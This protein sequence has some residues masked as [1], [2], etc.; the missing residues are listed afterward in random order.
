MLE[1]SSSYTTNGDDQT[2]SMIFGKQKGSSVKSNLLNEWK[3]NLVLH[4]CTV[5]KI[6]WIDLCLT[7]AVSIAIGFKKIKKMFG[8]RL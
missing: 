6:L 7:L 8:L 5:H 2:I 1:T 4:L 3:I